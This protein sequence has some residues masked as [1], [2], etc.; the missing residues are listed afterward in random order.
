MRVFAACVSLL[1]IF[2]SANVEASNRPN[3]R[4]EREAAFEAGQLTERLFICIAEAANANLEWTNKL[5]DS[6]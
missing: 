2:A 6:V 1:M 3:Q 4:A 5:S